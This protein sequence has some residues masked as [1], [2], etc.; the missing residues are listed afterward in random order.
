VGYWCCGQTEPHREAAATHFLGLAGYETYCPR[1]KLVR[2]RHGRKVVSKVPLFPSYLFIWITTGWWSA[3][4]CP[5][6][7]R[8]LANGD[9]P[10]VV[11]DNLINEIKSRERG[12]LIE[13]PRRDAFQVGDQVRILAGPFEGHLGLYAGMRAHERVLVLLALLGGS[14]GWSCPRPTSRPCAPEGMVRLDAALAVDQRDA[15]L[16]EVADALQGCAEIGPGTVHRAIA[17]AQRRHWDPPD[18]SHH[19][20]KYR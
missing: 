7:V 8:L 15:F 10:M 5:G 3:R 17:E 13:L 14:N 9:T 1:L 12:G 19:S 2:P 6:I 16:Q 4:W 18:L 20:G 11:P